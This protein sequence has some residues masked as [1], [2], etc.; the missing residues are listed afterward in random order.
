M[1][2]IDTQVQDF[3]NQFGEYEHPKQLCMAITLVKRLNAALRDVTKW[4]ADLQ[5]GL[6][7]N[8]V[9]CGHRYPPGTP[10]V[11]DKVLFEHIKQCPKHPLAKALE[12]NKMLNDALENGGIDLSP[13]HCGNI[14]A[15]VPEGIVICKEC[16]ERDMPS[17]DKRG[18]NG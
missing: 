16:M 11:R 12:E 9:Y 13:C 18:E 10:D 8:C 17:T 5:S 6:H 15:C 1:T 2:E 14:V 7:I 4:V 3:L